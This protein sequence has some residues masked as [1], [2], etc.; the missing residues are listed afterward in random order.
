MSHPQQI[1]QQVFGHTDFRGRQAEI[2]DRLLEGRHALVIMPTGM[3]KSLCYQIPAI[4]WSGQ[5]SAPGEGPRR[6]LTLVIS[7]LIALM[8]DQVD[9]LRAKGVSAT[10]INSSL[11]RQER[12]DRYRQLAAGQFD[13]LYVTPERFRK[14]EFLESIDQRNIQLMAVDEAHCISEWG[15]DFRPDYTRVGEIR[16]RLGNPT[17]LALTAT[18]TPEVQA[19]IVDQLS[20]APDQ[21]AMFH[22]GI[23]RPN[24]QLLV[25]HVWDDD[26]KLAAILETGQRIEGSGIVYF[27]LIRT[28]SRFS[29][30]LRERKI[31]HLVYH[32]DLDRSRR[33]QLQDQFMQGDDPLVLATNAFGMGI[34]KEAIRFVMHAELPGSLE[35]YYQEIGRAGRDGLP[36]ECRLLYDQRDLATQMEFLQW[37]N[38]DAQFYQRVYDFLE[39]E[40]E[41][42]NSF[43]IDWLRERLHHKQKHDRR[44]E[45]CLAML[46]RWGVISGT[47]SP[48]QL[49][50]ESGL[51]DRFLDAEWTELKRKGD[52]HKLLKMVEYANHGGDRKDFIHAYFGLR[53]PRSN[54]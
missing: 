6:G 27:T 12:T 35:S 48:L 31:P 25:D 53:L 44:L 49:R 23:Q 3:G 41:Q 22:H 17:T 7:P 39:N 32:G 18:A 4:L 11:G 54:P 30:L 33:R 20:L 5:A 40:L 16:A 45:T 43:G 2:I 50:I 42:V 10:F 1:L 29:E 15:H 37:S 8:K 9:S 36:S 47:L 19:D 51:P 38:P 52:Q 34:D 21:M 13:L 24:L 14:P 46:E 26:E 28:L